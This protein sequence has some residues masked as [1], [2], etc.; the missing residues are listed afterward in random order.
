MQENTKKPRKFTTVDTDNW[1][2]VTHTG[3][4]IVGTRKD[5]SKVALKGYNGYLTAQAVARQAGGVAVR[6]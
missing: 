6:E 3:K 1:K 4:T 2:V 5:G